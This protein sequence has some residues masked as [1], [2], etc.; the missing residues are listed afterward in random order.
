MSDYIRQ[1]NENGN[2]S[3]NKTKSEEIT[4][5]QLQGAALQ[6]IQIKSVSQVLGIEKSSEISLYADK[7]NTLIEYAK[8]QT[9]DLSPENLKWV[10]RSLE[11]KLGT[12]PFSEKRISYVARYAYLLL[13]ENK[14]KKEKQQ[15]EQL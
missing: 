11:L 8:T 10:I 4:P 2:T 9:K 3:E 6:E 15:F 7:I 12:P 5:Q 14:I 13:E 1:I